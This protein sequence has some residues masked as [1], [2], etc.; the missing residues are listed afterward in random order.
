MEQNLV[1]QT[2]KAFEKKSTFA[3][4]QL[5]RLGK[6]EIQASF[7]NQDDIIFLLG[8]KNRIT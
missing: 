3:P 1:K 6:T 7:D 5:S 8:R 4:G 2:P